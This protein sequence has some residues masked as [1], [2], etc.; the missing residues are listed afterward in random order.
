LAE[1]PII[2]LERMSG[3]TASSDYESYEAIFKG[4]ILLIESIIYIWAVG[5]FAASVLLSCEYGWNAAEFNY[6]IVWFWQTRCSGSTI[7][8]LG[9][10]V[11]NHFLLLY[12]CVTHKLPL[13]FFTEGDDGIWRA[14]HGAVDSA[15][16]TQFGIKIK[17][18]R[19][20]AIEEASFCGR[21]FNPRT[22]VTL[23]DPVTAMAKV[24]V[25]PPDLVAAKL[26]TKL[27]YLRAKA[28]SIAYLYANG[29]DSLPIVSSWARR[30]LVETSGL[31]FD[32]DSLRYTDRVM[33]MSR[34]KIKL[35]QQEALDRLVSPLMETRDI[36][37]DL[38]GIPIEVQ[39]RTEDRIL[40][41]LFPEQLW[42]PELLPF[43]PGP[44]K[45]YFLEYTY[46]P[47]HPFNHRDLPP[48][49]NVRKTLLQVSKNLGT[50]S[51]PFDSIL[52]WNTGRLMRPVVSPQASYA[53][54]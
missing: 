52:D 14:R 13:N 32:R 38:Y 35:T 53:L 34:C 54:A 49:L 19:S 51:Q 12:Y 2:L 17:I 33:W 4:I 45:T 29:K 42:L 48:N 43:V 22:L 20:R 39:L 5:A 7:T 3:E 16:F 11:L 18:I 47:T 24:G 37:R 44:Y 26:S 40:G 21:V 50:S 10:G 25:L 9:N 27:R 31:P 28:F 15:W 1:L 30:V 23:T 41:T 36:V 8:S 6:F 46:D